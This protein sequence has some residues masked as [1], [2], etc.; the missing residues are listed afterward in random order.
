MEFRKE[1]RVPPW[2]RRYDTA[3]EL[4]SKTATEE[5]ARSGANYLRALSIAKSSRALIERSTSS[6]AKGLK[7]PARPSE[8]PSPRPRRRTITRAEGT[9]APEK[10][11]ARS[12]RGRATKKDRLELPVTTRP[13]ETDLSDPTDAEESAGV[14]PCGG[15]PQE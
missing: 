15:D 11:R 4:P 13:A 12:D 8:P 2:F 10:R 5:P 14:T 3:V 1:E 7:R 9:P 6:K